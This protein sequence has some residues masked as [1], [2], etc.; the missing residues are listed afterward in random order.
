MPKIKIPSFL[1]ITLITSLIITSAVGAQRVRVSGG[2]RLHS[3]GRGAA[4]L[5]DF[6]H[7]STISCTNNIGHGNVRGHTTGAFPV[8]ISHRGSLSHTSCSA[9]GGTVTLNIVCQ[10]A[11][12][13]VTGSTVADTT[14]LLVTNINCLISIPALPTC[15]ETVVG[16][17]GV[18][19]NNSAHTLRFN[20][21]HSH[22]QIVAA[23][24]GAGC[25]FQRG[26]T[27][28]RLTGPSGADYTYDV[29]PAVTIVS[30]A[31]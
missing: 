19:Y 13:A 17:V 11:R 20:P 3:V 30:S 21:N 2:T 16:S 24:G 12:L 29:S 4:V 25:P 26:S 27:S 18:S 10:H 31:S 7:G 6:D 5:T 23:T 8:A 9:V 28:V 1:L 14:P 22:V 15:N